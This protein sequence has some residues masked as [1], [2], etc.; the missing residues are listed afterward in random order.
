MAEHVIK[1]SGKFNVE[2]PLKKKHD[3]QMNITG[4]IDSVKDGDGANGEQEFEYHFK[5]MYGEVI[6]EKGQTIK[7]VKKGSQSQ[8]LRFDII[9]MDLNYESTMSDIMAY[10]PE[11]LDFIKTLK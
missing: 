5:P 7:V 2:F 4:N 6:N 1:V 3:Y 9:S 11:I 10:L 8:K